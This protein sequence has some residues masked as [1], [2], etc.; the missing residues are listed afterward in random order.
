MEVGWKARQQ[1]VAMG[2]PKSKLNWKQLRRWLLGQ[3]QRAVGSLRCGTSGRGS[4]ASQA[5]LRMLVHPVSCIQTPGT[6]KS[7]GWCC[8]QTRKN[9]AVPQVLV[10]WVDKT[11]PSPWNPTASGETEEQNFAVATALSSLALLSAKLLC[12]PTSQPSPAQREHFQAP[13]WKGRGC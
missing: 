9:P 13:D 2:M 4:L 12:P 11:S 10:R 8:L 5:G 1:G 6:R 7:E 3:D